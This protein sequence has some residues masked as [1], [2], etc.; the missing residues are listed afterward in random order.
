MLLVLKDQRATLELEE[1][2]ARLALQE[3]Q[4]CK[5]QEVILELQVL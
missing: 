4:V 3:Q 2:Q 5:G 1:V